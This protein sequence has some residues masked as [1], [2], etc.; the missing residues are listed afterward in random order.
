M[1]IEVVV[2]INGEV[3]DLREQ[4]SLLN[5]VHLDAVS[6]LACMIHQTCTELHA[7]LPPEKRKT[8]PRLFGGA[9]R[10]VDTSPANFAIYEADGSLNA[11]GSPAKP[12]S[13]DARARYVLIRHNRTKK[14]I[15][16]EEAWKRSTNP[17]C[18]DYWLARFFVEEASN[19]RNQLG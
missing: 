1:R 3:V 19:G 12:I 16:Y 7:E 2:R 13:M 17:W 10:A 18:L 5:E 8:D 9:T 11:D 14:P 6:R 4:K 15:G